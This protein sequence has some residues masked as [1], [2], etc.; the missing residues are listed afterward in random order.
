MRPSA[1]SALTVSM[2][3]ETPESTHH[4]GRSPVDGC[5]RRIYGHTVTTRWSGTEVPRGDDY[6]A[7]FERLAA[8]GVDVHGEAACVERL[9]SARGVTSGR[10][11]D[12]GCGTGR[13]AI[14]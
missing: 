14:E 4:C 11:L 2:L 12:A 5:D 8:T 6:D 7:R 9:L 10:V 13:V 3:G 1:M